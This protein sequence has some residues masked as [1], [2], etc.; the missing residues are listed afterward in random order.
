MNT[1][2]ADGVR[3]GAGGSV[4]IDTQVPLDYL[5]DFITARGNANPHFYYVRGG[6][7]RVRYSHRPKVRKKR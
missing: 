4:H 5:P 3:G 7:G 2:R 1:I 6:G